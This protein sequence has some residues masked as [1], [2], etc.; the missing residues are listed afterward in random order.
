MKKEKDLNYIASLEKAIK[1]KYGEAAIQ[2]PASCWTPEKEK[3]YLKQLKKVIERVDSNKVETESGF[4][5]EQKLINI[6][7]VET[8]SRCENKITTLYDK[9][10][11]SK[12]SVCEKC[13]ILY[14]EDR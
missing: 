5:L 2:N 7:K 12:L 14:Y 1:K 13:Y 8:C 3:E 10:Y 6:S 4:L 9:I 11:F